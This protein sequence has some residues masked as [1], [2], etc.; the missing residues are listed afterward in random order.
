MTQ[1]CAV[2]PCLSEGFPF[3]NSLCSFQSISLVEVTEALPE[4]FRLAAS[5]RIAPASTPPVLDVL[6][7]ASSCKITVS[8]ALTV[9]M[10]GNVPE[11]FSRQLC[12]RCLS[13]LCRCAPFQVSI[14]PSDGNFHSRACQI[15]GIPAAKVKIDRQSGSW[16]FP[17]C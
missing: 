16:E 5:R 9:I 13:P 7:K 17:I 10:P 15:P 11:S 12:P 14:F 3:S 8:A 2:T 6:R 4:S 1:P